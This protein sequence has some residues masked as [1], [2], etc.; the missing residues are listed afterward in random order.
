MVSSKFNTVIC[1]NCN[2]QFLRRN[3]RMQPGLRIF[4]TRTCHRLY[5]ADRVSRFWDKVDKRTS[6]ECWL[7]TGATASG[8]GSFRFLQDG[9]ARMM[10]AHCVAYILAY[11]TIRASYD[12]C[13]SCDTRLCVNPAHLWE[14]TP[15]DNIQ[16][17]VTK[18]RMAAGDRHYLRKNPSRVEGS[19]NPQAKI[20]E[21]DVPIIRALAQAGCT[22]KSLSL[23]YGVSRS[24]V[25]MIIERR[26]WTH[27]A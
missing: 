22:H 6:S 23:R 24:A 27:I 4:C 1:Q 2:K 13:H 10:G 21:A 26:T 16:D 15:H 5:K 14:G 9:H 25:S 3:D 11:G 17:A 7:W 19:H 8:Y 12:I 20:Q 18:G